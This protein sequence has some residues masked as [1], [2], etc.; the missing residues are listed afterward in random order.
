MH[1]RA[2]PVRTRGGENERRG[3]DAAVFAAPS[4]QTQVRQADLTLSVPEK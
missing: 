1:R 4:T 3:G 2:V